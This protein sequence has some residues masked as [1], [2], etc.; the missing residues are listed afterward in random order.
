[1]TINL[2]N[3]DYHDNQRNIC[4]YRWLLNIQESRNPMFLYYIFLAALSHGA[5]LSLR[6]RDEGQKNWIPANN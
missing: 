3:D 2:V 4:Q 1:M 6:M 5:F